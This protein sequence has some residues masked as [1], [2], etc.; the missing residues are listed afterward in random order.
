MAFYEAEK[1]DIVI[2]EG[3]VRLVRIR[4]CVQYG[5]ILFGYFVNDIIGVFEFN[6]FSDDPEP[7]FI[8]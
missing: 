7:N 2:F 6:Q 1:T 4:R 3:L 8:L 5:S